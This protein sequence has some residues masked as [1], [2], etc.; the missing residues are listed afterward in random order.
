M[1]EDMIRTVIR[2]QQTLHGLAER[3]GQERRTQ[4][5]LRQFLAERT[6][7]RV[8]DR[9]RWLYAVHDEGAPETVVVRADHDAVPTAEGAAHLCGHDGHT[10]AL[11]GL[12]LLL[13]GQSLGKNVI[14]LFQHAEETGAGA[15][16]CR[17]LFALEGLRPEHACILGC[18]NIPGEPLGTLLLRRGSFACASCGVE[19]SLAGRP[20]HAAYPENGRS[21][22]AAA[23][24]L[25]LELPALARA[26]AQRHGCMCLATVVG[27]RLGERAFGVAASE[28]QLWITLRAERQEAFD[29]L[30]RRTEESV[31][32][33]AE[34]EGLGWTLR[35]EDEF[36]ATVNDAALEAKLEAVCA[37]EGL[38]CRFPAQPFRWSEDFGHYGRDLPACFFGVGAGEE[39]P[40]LH[41]AAYV[42]PAALAPQLA[43]LWLRLLRG[44]P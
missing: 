21:P 26:L 36:P 20:A 33:A 38:P 8:E 37:A 28:G 25:A 32:A 7:L 14:L 30:K 39:T 6:G 12:A 24:R 22:V 43:E 34:A 31:R 15:P 11:L 13:E 16:E 40:P 35:L 19:I 4:A 41:T 17:A 29:E 2:A 10:A 23:A 5:C 1:E 42:W 27:M 18:H 44:L 3:S 9:G